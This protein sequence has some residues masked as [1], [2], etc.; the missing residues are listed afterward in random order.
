MRFWAN[1]YSWSS[2]RLASGFRLSFAFV[3]GQTYSQPEG[4]DP[5]FTLPWV[6]SFVSSDGLP[7]SVG[8]RS[9]RPHAKQNGRVVGPFCLAL[10]GLLC[11]ARHADRTSF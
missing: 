11:I 6:N 10:T 5:I 3:F 1:K 8:L 4:R 2:A 7:V 9:R